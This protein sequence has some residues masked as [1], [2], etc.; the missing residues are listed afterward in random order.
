MSPGEHTF[1][2][3]PSNPWLSRGYASENIIYFLFYYI[4]FNPLVGSQI[5][6]EKGFPRNHGCMSGWCKIAREAGSIPLSKSVY[7][8]ELY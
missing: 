5:S 6:I 4:F 1:Q 2:L 8:L 7:S 3:Y